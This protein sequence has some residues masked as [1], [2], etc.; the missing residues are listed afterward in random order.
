MNT[1]AQKD[2]QIQQHRKTDRYFAAVHQI[3]KQFFKHHHQTTAVGTP[4]G[5]TQKKEDHTDRSISCYCCTQ[6][7]ICASIA[8]HNFYGE[9]RR[10]SRQPPLSL[11]DFPPEFPVF[12]YYYCCCVRVAQKTNVKTKIRGV[13]STVVLLCS[14]Y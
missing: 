14:E 12:A 6:Y 4:A 7:T 2:R 3:N 11:V 5:V 13:R 10:C 9:E 1:A 8:L